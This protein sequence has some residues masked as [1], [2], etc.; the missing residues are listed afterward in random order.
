MEGRGVLKD[1][2]TPLNASGS[3]PSLA[4]ANAMREPAKRL[5]LAVPNVDIATSRDIEMR[6]GIAPMA[7]FPKVCIQ[8]KSDFMI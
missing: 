4:V 8:K 7:A 3:R 6:P 5:P 2:C 1:C